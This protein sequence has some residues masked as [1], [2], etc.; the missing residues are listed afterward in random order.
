M[1]SKEEQMDYREAV[2]PTFYTAQQTLFMLA[3]AGNEDAKEFIA[4]TGIKNQLMEG[5]QKPTGPAANMSQEDIKALMVGATLAIEARYE[6]VSRLLKEGGYK[7][8]LDIACGFTP[9]ALYCDKNGIDYVGVD[10]PVVA[11][12]LS[13]YAEQMMP[14]K[15]HAI[16]VGGD[17]TNAASLRAAADMMEGEIMISCEGLL[18]YLSWDELGQ[19]LDGIRGILVE[20][21]G[22]WYTSDLGV[23]YQQISARNMSSPEAAAEYED[24]R[25]KIMSSSDIYNHL[26]EFRDTERFGAFI[27]SHGIQM[28]KLPFYI[29]GENLNM[30]KAVMP[31]KMDGILDALRGF[32]VF[33][34]TPDPAFAGTAFAS[35][36]KEIENLKIDFKVENGT[37][38]CR[39]DGR[40]D[41]ISAP[42]L[43]EVF[44][45]HHEGV[46]AMCLDAE[47]LE[48]ISSAGL[49]VL[50]MA[51]KALGPG[52][53]T[54][55]N[56]SPSVKE[57][58][59][60]TGFDQMI[61]VE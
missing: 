43:L 55:K 53:V 19:F 32:Y 1:S 14:G 37:L 10:V 11:D 47:K 40:I 4:K 23:D 6:T 44:E 52:S 12:R 50:M 18:T 36:A 24:A 59:E 9:R 25:K 7:N 33:K 57:I 58:M 42:T 46:K 8:L 45:E 28:E 3:A 30:L 56:T 29:E 51:V 38:V 41:T 60:T 21:G 48:Y 27:K 61:N 31:D 49:R 20:H 16:Y 35:G 22:A 26:E 2:N 17:A 34:M 54:M 5:S 15:K 39:A 13:Q